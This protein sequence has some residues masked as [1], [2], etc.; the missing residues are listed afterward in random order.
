M[1]YSLHLPTYAELYHYLYDL[2][3]PCSRRWTHTYWMIGTLVL[4]RGYCHDS[5]YDTLF[6]IL[7]PTQ[8]LAGLS[9]ISYPNTNTQPPVTHHLTHAYHLTHPYL[10]LLIADITENLSEL[11]YHSYWLL[12]YSISTSTPIRLLI[13]LSLVDY[14]SV[15]LPIVPNSSY[16]TIATSYLQAHSHLLYVYMHMYIQWLPKLIQC[17]AL[18]HCLLINSGTRTSKTKV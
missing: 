13:D 15:V 1:L 10:L 17:F 8:A 12:V 3:T 16:W 5:V 6:L 14:H 7:T 4:M 2:C 11:I 9:L 18:S